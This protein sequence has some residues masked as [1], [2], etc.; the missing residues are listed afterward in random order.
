MS[1]TENLRTTDV[2]IRIKPIVSV[3]SGM[4]ENKL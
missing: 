1:D 4:M 3:G 2:T